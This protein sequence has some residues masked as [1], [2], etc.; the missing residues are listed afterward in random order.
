MVEP[1]FQMFECESPTCRL[2]FPSD[3]S[4]N[5]IDRCPVCGSQMK[6]IGKPY[7][8]FHR[9]SNRQWL[10]GQSITILL[11]NLRSAENVGS[12]FRTANGA[13]VSHIYCCGTTPSPEHARVRKSSLGAEMETGWSYHTNS[14][15]I[16]N[17]L[18]NDGYHLVA[19]ESTPDSKSLMDFRL[20]DQRNQH[21]VLI[22]GNEVSG[23][24]PEVLSR[25]NSVLHIPMA[26]SKTSLNVAVTAG[27]GLYLIIKSIGSDPHCVENSGTIA[28][29]LN[30]DE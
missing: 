12:I 2:R 3:L 6:M 25:A 13:G 26:G 28:A 5:R 7:S 18:Q 23:I 27:I 8:N 1:F 11:D 20:E 24:D 17:E 10:P 29:T 4:T 9:P 16:V 19:L 22:L 14:L 15:D 30:E 21:L